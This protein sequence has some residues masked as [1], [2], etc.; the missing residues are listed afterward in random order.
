[1]RIGVLGT[2]TVGRTLASKLAELGHDVVMGTRDASN[3]VARSWAAESGGGHG[4]F[5]ASASH[6][7]L[8]V[9]ATNGMGSMEALAAAG[10]EHLAA[11]V[12][13]D[14]A[15]PLDFSA[16]M[17]PTLTVSNTD[18]LAEQ[19]QAAFPD[20]KVVKALNTVNADLMVDPGRLGGAHQL[21]VCGNDADAKETVT[22]ILTT[23]GWPAADIVDLGDITAARG[24]EMYLALWVRLMQTL[25]TPHF[26]VGIVR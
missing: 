19:I 15:N 8:I 6:G 1:M 4:T 17:P 26:N 3:E 21:F 18:S 7:E 24:T 25:G 22:Q 13:I 9:N 10:A 20:A 12:L 16:G 14:V 23:F 5:A 2:G 11:K